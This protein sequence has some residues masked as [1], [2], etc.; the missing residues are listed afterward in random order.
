MRKIKIYFTSSCIITSL[1]LS[2]CHTSRHATASSDN[3]P[4]FID[5]IYVGH[6]NNLGMNVI[7]DRSNHNDHSDYKNIKHKEANNLQKKYADILGLSPHEIADVSLYK[8]IDDW[9]G[10]PHVM[11]GTDQSGIDCS[12]FV[13]LLYQQV[14]GIDLV[15][16]AMEQFNNC[17]RIKHQSKLEEG[18][19]V[20]FHVHSRHVTHVGVYL[21]NNYFV[22][23]SNSHGVMISNLD[24]DYWHHYFAGGGKVP[25]N[26]N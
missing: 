15:R 18:D 2:S 9:Y 10:V 25:R 24:E 20:F 26:N 3:K 6:K 11:G 14:F 13:Q 7:N 21:A 8:F 22:H 5:D 16:T 12:A 17:K 23:V 4:K 1:L 19:L